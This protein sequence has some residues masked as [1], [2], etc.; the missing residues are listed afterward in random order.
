VSNDFTVFAEI[1]TIIRSVAGD[2][3]GQLTITPMSTFHDLGL[4]SLDIVLLA[5]RIEAHFGWAINVP[6]LAAGSDA[7]SIMD[8][9]VQHLV[10]HIDEVLKDSFWS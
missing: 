3:G 8:M 2:V 9:R 5:G 4:E 10:D 1:E 7:T 6:E